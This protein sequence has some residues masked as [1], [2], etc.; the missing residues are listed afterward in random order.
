MLDNWHYSAQKLSEYTRVVSL[1]A[2]NHGKS[3]HHPKMGFKEMA[4]DVMQVMES[5]GDQKIDLIGHSMGGKTAM[6]FAMMFPYALRKLVVVDIAPKAYKPGHLTYFEAFQSIDL[7]SL[8][9]RSE[10]DEA[11]KPFAPEDSVRQFLLKNLEP[12]SGGGY[13]TKFNLDALWNHYDEIIGEITLSSPSFTGET[14]FISGEKSG[15]I[16]EKDHDAILTA[17]PLA[18]FQWISKAGHWVHADNPEEFL[19]KTADFLYA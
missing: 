17:F 12:V 7:K 8:K 3:F 13:K 18:E 14:L 11:F 6:T 2:R 19:Q 15:Y 1:D 9:S 5:L 10:A 16:K 4:E